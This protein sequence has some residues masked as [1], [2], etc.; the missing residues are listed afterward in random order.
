MGACEAAVAVRL[1]SPMATALTGWFPTSET[2]LTEGFAA[3][4]AARYSP[5]PR[6][7]HSKPSKLNSGAERV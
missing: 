3:W 1:A 2:T 6:H 5:M 7:F 4:T